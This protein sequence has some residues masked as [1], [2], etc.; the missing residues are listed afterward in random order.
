MYTLFLLPSLGAILG[1][2]YHLK[3]KN[4]TVSKSSF[5][6]IEASC[7]GLLIAFVLAI[8]FNQAV[9]VHDVMSE[10]VTLVSMPNQSGNSGSFI[11]GS[12]SVKSGINYHFLTKKSDGSLVPDSVPGSDLVYIIEDAKLSGVAYWQT[13]TR[14][15]D[16]SHW[17]FKWTIFH[18][19][20]AHIIRQEFRVPVGSIIQQLKIQ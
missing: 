6:T 11:F 19:D 2:F 16:R 7:V 20:D 8:L 4:R 10:P 3:G 15:A 1:I 17:L 13:T 5:F 14:Q 12:G 9:P 18:R